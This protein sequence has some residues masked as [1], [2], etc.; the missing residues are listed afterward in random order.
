MK[1]DMKGS[2]RSRGGKAVAN[3]GDP[4]NDKPDANRSS[5]GRRSFNLNNALE[6]NRCNLEVDGVLRS[7]VQEKETEVATSRGKETITTPLTSTT[8]PLMP[9]TTKKGNVTFP[10]MV[11]APPEALSQ[12]GTELET[13]SD[14]PFL[15]HESALERAR[16]IYR[17]MK[18]DRR[19]RLADVP[20]STDLQKWT[21]RWNRPGGLYGPS[22]ASGSTGVLPPPLAAT[23][24]AQGTAG[25][26][27]ALPPPT[28]T[29][30]T[31]TT[32]TTTKTTSEMSKGGYGGHFPPLCAPMTRAGATSSPSTTGPKA[33]ATGDTGMP[34]P[35]LPT[36]IRRNRSGS[37]RKLAVA[38]VQRTA[39]AVPRSYS[40]SSSNSTSNTP[41]PGKRAGVTRDGYSKTFQEAQKKLAVQ[42][43]AGRHDGAALPMDDF[44][45]RSTPSDTPMKDVPELSVN[46]SATKQLP[47]SWGDS[48]DNSMLNIA[49]DETDAMAS[50][51]A[52]KVELRE[53]DLNRP[54][55]QSGG[56]ERTRPL[57]PP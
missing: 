30:P 20:R 7:G 14:P 24:S 53:G 1:S 43:S 21:E 19:A 37:R 44:T 3:K 41:P 29:T 31:T 16:W 50:D 38:S 48:N 35:P 40:S 52:A 57:L 33:G 18:G 46:S 27:N 51:W 39:A 25:R 8:A 28:A 47:G 5:G 49:M 32:T 13:T 6:W 4:D 55:R 12:P 17:G 22:G 9:S 10:D 36:T 23:S 45:P 26:A 56:R 2:K 54:E 15:S 34:P 11:T 42:A